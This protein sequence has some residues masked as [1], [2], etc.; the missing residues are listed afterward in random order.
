MLVCHLFFF[1]FEVSHFPFSS[2]SKNLYAFCICRSVLSVS[3]HLQHG[4]PRGHDKC[5][6]VMRSRL[7]TE[8]GLANSQCLSH[9]LAKDHD[10]R[11]IS[12]CLWSWSSQFKTQK[13]MINIIYL[14]YS[15]I[16]NKGYIFV[17]STLALCQKKATPPSCKFDKKG[18]IK[19]SHHWISKAVSRSRFTR[20]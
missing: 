4:Y 19:T 7:A 15:D 2:E 5:W 17:H 3:T 16:S 14:M 10:S 18:V 9:V 12:D 11:A 8:K 6:Q 20:T 13:K 1:H